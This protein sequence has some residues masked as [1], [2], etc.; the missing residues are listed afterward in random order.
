[1]GLIFL[2]FQLMYFHFPFN[3]LNFYSPARVNNKT[4]HPHEL[5]REQES[6]YHR[7]KKKSGNTF[8]SKICISL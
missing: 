6:I 3:Y 1:M 4:S 7:E 2:T 5:E 8:D